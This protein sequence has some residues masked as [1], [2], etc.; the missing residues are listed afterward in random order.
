MVLQNFSKWDNY[1]KALKTRKQDDDRPVIGKQTISQNPLV[2]KATRIK[3]ITDAEG[4]KQASLNG[5][6]YVHGDTMYITGSKKAQ[7]WTDNIKN[8]PDWQLLNKVKHIGCTMLRGAGY[9]I[10]VI[11]DAPADWGNLRNS[12]R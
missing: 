4:F 12:E 6:T 5:Q 11:P 3:P 9:D 1:S 10:P 8:V 2:E 7:D